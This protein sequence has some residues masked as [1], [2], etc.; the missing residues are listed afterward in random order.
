MLTVKEYGRIV[1]MGI[2]AR[3]RRDKIARR[4][5]PKLKFSALHSLL[6]GKLSFPVGTVLRI[7]LP[8]DYQLLNR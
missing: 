6:K 8:A 1:A 4:K 7:R 5:N 2:Y 3:R